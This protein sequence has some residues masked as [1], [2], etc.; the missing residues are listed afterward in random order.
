MGWLIWRGGGVGLI[1]NTSP[2]G[3]G[4]CLSAQ[5]GCALCGERDSTAG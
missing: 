3:A 5:T 1:K 2:G 4:R